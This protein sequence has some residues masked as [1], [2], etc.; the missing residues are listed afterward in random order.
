[1]SANFWQSKTKK[2][3]LIKYLL[4][5]KKYT[6]VANTAFARRITFKHQNIKQASQNQL[7]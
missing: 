4:F 6:Q 3:I 2:Q 5:Y 7:N 1:M